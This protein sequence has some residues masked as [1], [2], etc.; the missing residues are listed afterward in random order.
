[1][2]KKSSIPLS[3]IMMAIGRDI[4]KKC[5]GLPLAANFLGSLLSLKRDENYWVSVNIDKNLWVQPENTRVISILKLSYDNLASPLKQC[6]SYCCLFPKDWEIE[7][8]IL[9]SMWMAEGFIQSNIE[10]VTNLGLM[11]R[12]MFHKFVVYNLNMTN[13]RQQQLPKCCVRQ[14]ICELLLV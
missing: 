2:Q 13:Y 10:I 3:Q 9:I 11:G 7:R 14:R 5:D 6:F 12:K 8:E 1:M 4:A